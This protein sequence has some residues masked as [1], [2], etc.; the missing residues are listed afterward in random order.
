LNP[1]KGTVCKA[2]H[3]LGITKM[4]RSDNPVRRKRQ[5]VVGETAKAPMLRD[6]RNA[7]TKVLGDA[8][9][10]VVLAELVKR[11]QRVLISFGDKEC[12]DLIFHA[13]SG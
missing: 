9:E 8:A 10:A 5:A 6:H 13:E 4:Q 3:L 2:F 7:G 12:Y 1:S 11:G